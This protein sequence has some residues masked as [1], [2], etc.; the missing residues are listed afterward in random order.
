MGAAAATAEDSAPF[1]HSTI[2]VAKDHERQTDKSDGLAKQ[3][4]EYLA[5]VSGGE[6]ALKTARQAVGRDL[7]KN[8]FKTAA[9][10]AAMSETAGFK[11]DGK[12]LR[13]TEVQRTLYLDAVV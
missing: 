12:V 1:K 11:A 2:S 13:L 7:E 8:E 9:K 3:I 10:A 6:A 4:R 5:S